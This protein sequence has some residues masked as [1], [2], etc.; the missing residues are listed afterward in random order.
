MPPKKDPKTPEQQ[1]EHFRK[2]V[3]RLIDAGELDPEKADE[4]LDRLVRRAAAPKRA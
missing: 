3:E 2:E 1:A 4:A